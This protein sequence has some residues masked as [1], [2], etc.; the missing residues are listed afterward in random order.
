MHKN[1]LF[2]ISPEHKT[3]DILVNELIRKGAMLQMTFVVFV[4]VCKYT[5][6]HTKR[7][8]STKRSR[9]LEFNIL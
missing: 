4:M 8:G 2:D 1:T 9:Y 3:T 7:C 5:I 6:T